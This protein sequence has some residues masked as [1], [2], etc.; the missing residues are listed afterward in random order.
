MGV[1][2]IVQQGGRVITGMKIRVNHFWYW[3]GQVGI[4]GQSFYCSGQ[5]SAG[6]TAGEVAKVFADA[7]KA[8]DMNL[9]SNDVTFMGSKCSQ[10]GAPPPIL[11]GICTGTDT[12]SVSGT[13]LPGEVTGMISLKTAV[14]GRAYRGRLY[15]PFIDGSQ[16]SDSSNQV[17]AGYTA[18]LQT[19]ADDICIPITIVGGSGNSVLDPII[20]HRG[21]GAYT[22]VLEAVALRKYGSQRRRGSYGQLNQPVIA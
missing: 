14:S 15:V 11:P 1:Y 18:Q 8:G 22:A 13:T 3:N 6:A 7:I 5:V 16:A 12:G 10:L 20:Y 9:W 2:T 4:C 21:S 17:P 19:L